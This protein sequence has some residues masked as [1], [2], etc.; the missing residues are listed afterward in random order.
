MEKFAYLSMTLHIDRKV[1][2]DAENMSAIT[3]HIL[4]GGITPSLFLFFLI[5]PQRIIVLSS[6]DEK[7]LK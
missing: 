1:P 7:C 3:D 2:I 6:D 4:T 5:L